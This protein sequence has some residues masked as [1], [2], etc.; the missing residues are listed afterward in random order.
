LDHATPAYDV[1]QAC[2]TG[3]QTV[4]AVANKIE[5][6]RIEAGMAGGVDTTSDAPIE[7]ND[8]LRELLLE[9]RRTKSAPGRVTLRGPLRPGQIAPEGPRDA[10]PPPGPA[11]GE[12]TAN[13]PRQWGLRR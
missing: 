5:T 9:I 2:D 12:H 7:I 11:R 8:D 4:I 6:G 1:Q 3:L 10:E 13:T